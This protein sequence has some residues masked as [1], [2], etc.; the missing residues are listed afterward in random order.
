[1]PTCVICHRQEADEVGSHIIS[2]FLLESMYNNGAKG[3]N[4]EQSFQI[5]AEGSTA[6]FGREV[7]P[8]AI[9]ETLGRPVTDADIDGIPNFYVRDH[10]FCVPCEKKLSFFESL[11][12]DKV[13]VFL[14]R[15]KK[16]TEQQLRIAHFFWL[17]II[18]RWAATRLGHLQLE[19][20]TLVEL[21]MI[22]D[23]IVVNAT[24][25]ADIEQN[26][27]DIP[28][29]NNL[30]IGYLP[31]TKDSGRH[32]FFSHPEKEEPYLLSVNQYIL[33]FN[34]HQLEQIAQLEA[35]IGVNLDIIATGTSPK[36]FSLA[37]REVVIAYFWKLATPYLEQQF[38]DIFIERY[39]KHHKRHPSD[40]ITEAFYQEYT[41]ADL[42]ETV[43]FAAQRQE[44][45]IQK[46]ILGGRTIVGTENNAKEF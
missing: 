19:R 13:A 35:E 14:A 5:G 12:K 31:L 25:A 33:A 26:C 8:E 24:S 16:L 41:Q 3:A 7:L 1:M 42:L 29:T 22:T 15:G 10:V 43:K 40:A 37:E 11:Y 32:Q 6:Y 44:E 45:L 18:Y 27:Q 20:P 17:T 39:T 28:I 30:F 23:A 36:I 9:E 4:K 2:R 34:Y 21:A 46:Y 38:K